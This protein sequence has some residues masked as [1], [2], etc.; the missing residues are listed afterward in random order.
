MRRTFGKVLVQLARKDPRIVLLIADVYQEMDNFA[1]EF[2]G[3]IFNV[4]L[5]EQT[6]IGMAAG[7]AIEGLRPVVYTLTPFLLERPFEQVKL[8]IDEQNLPVMLVGNSDY[9]T[10]GPTHRAL[11][12]EGLVALLKNTHGYFP[13]TGAE[14]EKAMLDAYLMKA[15]AV[16]CLKNEKAPMI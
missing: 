4:G 2:P 9:P 8:D 10:H 16:I 11:N 5:C 7:M 15:P 13:R 3:R 1:L 12:A 6:M 14:T